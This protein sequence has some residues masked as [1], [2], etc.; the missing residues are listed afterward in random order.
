MNRARLFGIIG[1][2]LLGA[3]LVAC[4]DQRRDQAPP[5]LSPA[6]GM[7]DEDDAAL[8]VLYDYR[9]LV[10][11]QDVSGLSK[12]T[13]VVEVDVYA[14][15]ARGF[16]PADER[17][18]TEGF[19]VLHVE[20][21]AEAPT[22]V[23]FTPLGDRTD[24]RRARLE[25]DL[26]EEGS[27]VVILSNTVSGLRAAH[28]DQDL[29]TSYRVSEPETLQASIFPGHLLR[30][31]GSCNHIYKMS[32]EVDGGGHLR[33]LRLHFSEALDPAWRPE[34]LDLAL[35]SQAGDRLPP[36]RARARRVSGNVIELDIP[37]NAQG[38]LE[39]PLASIPG[40]AGRFHDLLSCA[41]GDGLAKV[42]YLSEGL[43]NDERVVSPLQ[44]AVWRARREE[45]RS[46]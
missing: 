36:A 11:A 7:G 39:I 27:W 5:S 16:S 40:F 10:S 37:S 3:S 14:P 46:P 1:A 19:Q 15:S 38:F 18:V 26:T 28:A 9:Q 21:G 30:T 45:K 4:G 8:P 20:S 13:H 12:G 34:G 42:G 25:M 17:R 6:H 2:A 35:K 31:V 33:R 23:T 43:S 44:K 32:S 41:E 24:A 22:R 29:L